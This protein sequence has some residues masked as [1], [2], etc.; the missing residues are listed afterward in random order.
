MPVVLNVAVLTPNMFAAGSMGDAFVASGGRQVVD[1]IVAVSARAVRKARAMTG[2]S[3]ERG[4]IDV[5][6]SD[7]HTRQ[8]HMCVSPLRPG[9]GASGL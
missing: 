1:I 8:I 5:P 9:R 3:V 7:P 4:I 2:N 6:T